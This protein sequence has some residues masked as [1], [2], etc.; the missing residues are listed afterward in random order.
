MN[1]LSLILCWMNFIWSLNDGYVNELATYFW[2]QWQIQ[3][4]FVKLQTFDTF[5]LWIHSFRFVC[6]KV[7]AVRGGVASNDTSESATELYLIPE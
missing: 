4:F 5:A 1:E 2:S 7:N 6:W 3:G